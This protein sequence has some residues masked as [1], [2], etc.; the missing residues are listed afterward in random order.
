MFTNKLEAFRLKKAVR[1]CMLKLWRTA[2]LRPI[3]EAWYAVSRV[4]GIVAMV[5]AHNKASSW[6][7][8]VRYIVRL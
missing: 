7:R 4:K 1:G 2:K 6:V 5:A 3:L 8:G